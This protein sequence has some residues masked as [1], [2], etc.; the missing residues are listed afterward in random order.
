MRKEVVNAEA[1]DRGGD[2]ASRGSAMTLHL[3]ENHKGNAEERGIKNEARDDAKKGKR[4]KGD[5]SIYT[6]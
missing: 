5:L 6:A 4:P 2:N 3:P 1:K